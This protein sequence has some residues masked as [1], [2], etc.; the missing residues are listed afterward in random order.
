MDTTGRA[1]ILGHQIDQRLVQLGLSR[2]EFARRANIGRQTLQEIIHNP[3]KRISDKTFASLDRGLKW[4]AGTAKAFHQGN[5]NARAD[6]AKSVEDQVTEYL[7]QILNRLADMDIDQLERE[8]LLL[9]EESGDMPRDSETRRLIEL[10]VQKL[11]ATL[12]QLDPPGGSNDTTENP[13]HIKKQK[14]HPKKPHTPQ[15]KTHA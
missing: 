14:D 13:S 7:V 4:S 10:Q 3:D 2:R 12:M 1:S 11:V 8:V 6:I 9:E 15:S 5:E